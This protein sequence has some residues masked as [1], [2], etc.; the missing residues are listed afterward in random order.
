MGADAFSLLDDRIRGLLAEEGFDAPTPT[1]ALSIPVLLAGRDTLVIAPT[2]TGKTEAAVL[3]VLHRFLRLRDAKEAPRGIAILYVTP[4][5]ALN[6]DL[7]SRLAD[8]GRRLRVDVQVR[9]GDTPTSVRAAQSRSPPDML[10]TTPETLQIL[11]LGRNLRK[12]LEAVR[13]LVVDEVHELA[14]DERGA[15]L[16]V[17]M[18]RVERVASGSVQR[19]G[20]S[21]TVGSVAEV[22]RFLAGARP[23]PEVVQVPVVKDLR[24]VVEAPRPKPEH[25]AAAAVTYARP[26]EAALLLRCRELIEA[27]K[28]SLLFVNTRERAEI[29]TARFRLLDAS[30]RLGIHH[31]SLSQEARV[32]AEEQFKTGALRALV[33][34]SSM[35]LGIDIGEA[36]L[37]V[38]YGS[39]RQVT[40]LVQR[41]GRAGHRLGA[42]SNGA[43][44]SD[45]PDDVL[46]AAVIARRALA[47]ELEPVAVP[48][49]PLDVLANQLV[50]LAM[51]GVRDPD[52]AFALVTRA[53]P[54]HGLGRAA[55]DAV[56]KDLGERLLLDPAP[57]VLAPRG[58]AFPYFY[59][60]LSMIPDE[61][62]YRVRNVVTRKPVGRLDEAF[63]ASFVEPGASF[64]CRGEAWRVV[65]TDDEEVRVTP[66]KD[67]LGAVP[68]WIGEEIPVPFEVAQEAG[69]V[70]GELARVLA[71]DG[72]AAAEASLAARYPVSPDAAA[73]VLD[74][75]A[76]QG[77]RAVPTDVVT[78][79]ESGSGRCVWNACFGTRVNET[80]GRVLAS[81]LTARAGT[82]VGIDVDPYRIVLTLPKGVGPGLVREVLDGLDPDHLGGLLAVL[83]PG[84]SYFRHRLLH[85]A[86]RFGVIRKG[87]DYRKLSIE[88]LAGA[89]HGTPVHAEAMREVL[90]EKLDVPRAAE[91]LRRI[92][93]GAIALVAQ[94][95]SAIGLAGLDRKV[96]LISPARADRTILLA[97]KGR[98]EDDP[99]VIACMHCRA[100]SARTKVK[101]ARLGGC[102]KCKSVLLTAHKPWND[103]ATKALAR[104]AGRPTDAERHELERLTTASNL[105]I[106]HG[107]RALL[108]LSARGVGPDT[109]ARVLHRWREDEIAFLRD[110]LEAEVTY[111]RTRAF[112]D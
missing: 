111:A 8:W 2:G 107:N 58:R 102:P 74:L 5:R 88:R 41:V 94:P 66:V 63:V 38:Q 30:L 42:A 76:E 71:A 85:V 69:R 51:D 106:H 59:E 96:E 28:A 7:L 78:T 24:I 27:H 53:A 68:S 87:V 82:S 49:S 109:A 19:I 33:C 62:S 100:W 112:W 13:F 104:K 37:V 67:P 23:P 40:R 43:L 46:E 91:A 14:E 17:A 56:R 79:L 57:E 48:D 83:L 89:L 54:F 110:L 22:A 25:A 81:L 6:R 3:P 92:R 50:A 11:F 36:D 99:I 20:L 73:R 86:R 34:T 108:A 80:L 31:G 61:R 35:E 10:I 72:R 47:G 44:L 55:F 12:H 60:N 1:Q 65:E 98:L 39:P 9:H 21:A 90:H 45:E 93:N 32:A 18:E 26:E 84:T 29:L 95:L 64:I 52:E 4:L 70:R 16:A 77:P 103:L 15:Q 97:L 105:L 101:R 75:V